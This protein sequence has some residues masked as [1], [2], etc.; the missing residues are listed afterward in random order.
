LL[1][2]E[3]HVSDEELTKA[4]A[5]VSNIPYV[6]LSV[7]RIDPKTLDLLS[8]DIATHYMAVPL[9]KMQN[10]LV[11]AM[12]DADNVQAVDFLSNKIGKPLKVYAA[13]ESGL[14]VCLAN[15]QGPGKGRYF[16]AG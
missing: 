1:V 4:L 12:L 6:N 16:N 15:M 11:V 7:A 10:R 9:G 2:N 5:T 13:S 14:D 3:G 8:Q